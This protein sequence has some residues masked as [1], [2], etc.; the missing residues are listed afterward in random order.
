MTRPVA[1]GQQPMVRLLRE[2]RE[3]ISTL[4]LR[5]L[6]MATKKLIPW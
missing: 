6:A 1:D 4:E 2:P 5:M 3:N